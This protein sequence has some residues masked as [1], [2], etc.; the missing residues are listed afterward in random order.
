M[1]IDEGGDGKG[2][3]EGILRGEERERQ[4]GETVNFVGN[5]ENF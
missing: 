2:K 1:M 4:E 5:V 3:R